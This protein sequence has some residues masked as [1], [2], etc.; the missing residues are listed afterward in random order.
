MSRPDLRFLL[1][2]PAH[3]IACGLGAGLSPVAPGTAGTLLAWLLYPLVKAPFGDA[4][5]LL[6]L[7]AGFA[8]GVVA[9]HRTGRALGEADHGAIVWD[10]IVPFW[11]VLLFTPPTL[12]WQALAFLLFR[13]FDIVKPPPA[14]WIDGHM[15]HGFGVMADDVVAA[16]YTLLALAL[17]QRLLP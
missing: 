17:L 7:L 6:L 2:H 3:L 8:V 4:V 14:G 13:G 11:L 15:K 1:A 12:A 5:F 16:G 9:C 10:E